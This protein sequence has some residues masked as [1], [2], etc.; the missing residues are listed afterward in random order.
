[1]ATTEF[2][3]QTTFSLVSLDFTNIPAVNDNPNFKVQINFLG[4]TVASNGNNRFD[5]ITLKGVPISFSSPTVSAVKLQV[6]PNPFENNI[7]IIC[8]ENL[9]SIAVFDVLGKEIE[10]KLNIQQNQ[11]IIDLKHLKTGIYILK[12]HVNNGVQTLKIVK[13]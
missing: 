2:D 11:T 12:V 6:F 9:Q 3:V 1:L 7:Q 13:N 5:N 8:N 10:R 4:N